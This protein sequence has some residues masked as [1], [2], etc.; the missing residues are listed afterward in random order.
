LEE[1][2]VIYTQIFSEPLAKG[3]L[4]KRYKRFLA[5]VRTTGGRVLTIHCANT[6]S[7]KNCADSGSNIWFSLSSNKKRKYPHTWELVE[8]TRGDLIGVNTGLAN[9]LVKEALENGTVREL[10]GFDEIQTEVGYG[11]ERS[12]IDLL[13][14]K[15]CTNRTQDSSISVQHPDGRTPEGRISEGRTPERRTAAAAANRDADIALCYVEVKSVTLLDTSAG[16]GVGYFPDAVSLRGSKHLR[17]LINIHKQGHRAVLCYC[18]QHTG[19]REVRPADHIDK[20][21]GETLR[22]AIATGVEVI[23]YAASISPEEISIKH[24]LPVVLPNP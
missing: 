24:A 2:A 13:L 3:V 11:E 14:S 22:Q 9:R 6:G 20:I 10:A 16:D 7:M 1:S 4:L 21:Y 8:N 5:D 15:R 23:A 18:V 12:R 17:E 19:I